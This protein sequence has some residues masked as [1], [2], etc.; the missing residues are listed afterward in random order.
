MHITTPFART[1]QAAA[2]CCPAGWSRCT[3]RRWTFGCPSIMGRPAPSA[4]R[5]N[6]CCLLAMTALPLGCRLQVLRTPHRNPTYIRLVAVMIIGR[7]SIWRLTGQ[8]CLSMVL[9]AA[10]GVLCAGGSAPQRPGQKAIKVQLGKGGLPPHLQMPGSG[11]ATPATSTGGMS[12]RKQHG[13]VCSVPRPL[14]AFV[15]DLFIS[16]QSDTLR[17]HN[18]CRRLQRV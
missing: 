6:L 3:G 13:D 11:H 2:D 17:V 16:T 14:C 1:H 10:F 9:S 18:T 4:A 8:S 5:L 12:I 15:R 7:S